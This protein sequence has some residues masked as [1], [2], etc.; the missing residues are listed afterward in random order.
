MNFQLGITD[1]QDSDVY[2]TSGDQITLVRCWLNWGVGERGNGGPGE[3]G[4]GRM[5]DLGNVG[6]GDLGNVVMGDLGN[7][8]IGGDYDHFSG[9]LDKV[10]SIPITKNLQIFLYLY[11]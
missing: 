9:W 7:V 2:R 8:G 3:L 10:T 1:H 5:G 4:K 11:N 6:M